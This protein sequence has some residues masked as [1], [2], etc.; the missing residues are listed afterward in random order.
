MWFIYMIT[1]IYWGWGMYNYLLIQIIIEMGSKCLKAVK[2]NA[3][4]L[5]IN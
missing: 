1:D 3:L 4:N 2:Q 5:E